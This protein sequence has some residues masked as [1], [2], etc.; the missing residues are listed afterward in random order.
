MK[1]GEGGNRTCEA[2]L[3]LEPVTFYYKKE[4]DPKR[5]GVQS[6][7]LLGNQPLV[8]KHLAIIRSK[9]RSTGLSS[10]VCASLRSQM[11]YPVELRAPVK[12]G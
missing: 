4:I 12:S 1:R 6:V 5:N 10:F 7:L 11:L 9:R 2:I 8:G 3:A